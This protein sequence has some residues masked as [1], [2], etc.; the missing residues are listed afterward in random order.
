M[1]YP[2]T[3]YTSLLCSENVEV[4]QKGEKLG[5]WRK[6]RGRE[7]LPKNP[8]VYGIIHTPLGVRSKL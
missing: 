8:P 5:V 1:P 4:W 3:V 2:G 6:I 7:P